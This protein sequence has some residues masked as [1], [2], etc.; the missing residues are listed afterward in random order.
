MISGHIY[1][2]YET[3]RMLL[4][5]MTQVGYN[6]FIGKD[7]F[8]QLKYGRHYPFADLFDDRGFKVSQFSATGLYIGYQFR[9]L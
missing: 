4:A 3:N 2:A 6:K 8:V 7:F 9:T 5:A 1:N